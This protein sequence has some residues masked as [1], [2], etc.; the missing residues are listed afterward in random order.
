MYIIIIITLSPL[1]NL[2]KRV[3]KAILP[4][5]TTLTI[6]DYN[7]RKTSQGSSDAQNYVQKNPT[8]TYR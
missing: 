5:T 4:K 7:F 1:V 6:L 3:L 8:L 2:H